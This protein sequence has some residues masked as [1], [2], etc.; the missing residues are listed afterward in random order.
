MKTPSITT[1][2]YR[3]MPDGSGNHDLL[4]DYHNWDSHEIGLYFR[5]RGLG[6]YFEALQKHK[7]TGQLAPLLCDSDLKEMGV[8][9]V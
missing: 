7:I 6:A 5:K 2:R 9:V 8:D 1:G 4:S 3:A